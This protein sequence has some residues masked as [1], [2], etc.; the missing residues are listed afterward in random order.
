MLKRDIITIIYN[1]DKKFKFFII[2][3]GVKALK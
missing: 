1:T 2:N 3:I